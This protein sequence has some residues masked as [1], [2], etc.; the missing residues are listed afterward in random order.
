[1]KT[2]RNCLIIV[3]MVLGLIFVSS[4]CCWLLFSDVPMFKQ[5]GAALGLSE[6]GWFDYV[7]AM[8]VYTVLWGMVKG[9]I[10]VFKM[11]LDTIWE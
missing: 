7:I 4:Y 6:L 11:T 5:I 3:A 1:M 9:V 10:F 8:S 2:I